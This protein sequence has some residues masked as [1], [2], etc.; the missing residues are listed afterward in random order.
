VSRKRVAVALLVAITVSGCI[1]P[2]A[3]Y[4]RERERREATEA[5]LKAARAQVEELSGRLGRREI[6]RDSLG[7][8]RLELIDDVEDLRQENTELRRRLDETEAALEE[9]QE[10]LAG[11]EAAVEQIQGS[12]QSLVEQLEEEVSR[13]QI[14]IQQLQGRLQIRALERILFDSGRAQIK[15]EGRSVLAAVAQQLR[16]KQGYE[17]RI[18]G[19]TDNIP[20]STRDFPSNWELSCA[21]AAR[22]L[23]FLVE[24][25]LAAERMS[26]VGFGPHRPIDTND[27]REGRARNRRIEIVLVPESE[28]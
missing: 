22:V 10:R 23:R 6:E 18:E 8:E 12:Y 26:A 14:E 9:A 5:E 2:R 7:K 4:L 1:V 3:T 11:S 28:G 15:S 17:I 24:K 19:H 25:G 21:R 13:G 27:T 20:I 16:K